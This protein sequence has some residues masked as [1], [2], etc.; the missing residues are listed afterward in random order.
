[1][2]NLSAV[3]EQWLWV[4]NWNVHD[5]KKIVVCSVIVW[6]KNTAWFCIADF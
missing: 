2:V 5:A 3:G 6:K 4:E 1:M